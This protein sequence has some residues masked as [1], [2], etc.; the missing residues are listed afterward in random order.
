MKIL[1]I[2]EYSRHAENA[3]YRECLCLQRAFQR[4]GWEADV[5]GLGHSNYCV[6]P[7][8]NSYDVIFN[9]EN[10]G[11][12]WLPDLTDVTKPYKIFYAVDPHIRGLAPY[13]QIVK[14]QGYNMLFSAVRDFT[15]QDPQNMAWMPP[16]IDK[17]LFY[18]KNLT[19]D[20]S[21][22]FVGN[23]SE[24]TR[25]LLLEYMTTLY[26]LQQHIKIFGDA[27]VDLL[28]RFQIGFNKN[29]GN[30]TNYRSFESIACGAML[31]TDNNPAYHDLGFVHGVNCYLYSSVDDL[32]YGIKDLLKRPDII[33]SI[34][35]EGEKL[36]VNHTYDQRV[37]GMI[38][39]VK[40]K[41]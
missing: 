8:Y 35:K 2:Q 31:F 30:D 29:M 5:W 11:D 26:G 37:A 13:Q 15:A 39:F 38:D 25:K 7:D 6:F 20:I 4:A 33:Q 1:I 3:Q 16:A 23:E 36:A 24:F 40:S 32:K 22:G 28:N 14:N 17:D 10:Y 34:A 41:I 21:L 27:M 12:H 18:N 9:C 19:R